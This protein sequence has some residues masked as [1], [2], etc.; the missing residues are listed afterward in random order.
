MKPVRAETVCS[1][2][3]RNPAPCGDD[4]W[5][6][7]EGGHAGPHTGQEVRCMCGLSYEA[8]RDRFIETGELAA[9]ERMLPKVTP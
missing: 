1:H 9:L 8:A 3:D 6:L 7:E 4:R 5:C 2:G